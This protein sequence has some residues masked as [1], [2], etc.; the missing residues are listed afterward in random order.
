MKKIIVSNQLIKQIN[1]KKTLLIANDF[2]MN[3][4]QLID[5]ANQTV[6]LT[7]Q[8]GKYVANAYFSNQNKGIGWVYS[9][10]TA[11][12]SVSLLIEKFNKAKQLREKLFSDELTTAF[13]LFNESGDGLGGLKI[14]VY[15]QY[16]VF[17][18]YNEFIYQH[19]E[20][21]VSAFQ[22][23]F[24]DIIG[25]YVKHRFKNAKNISAHLFGE[26]HED[27]LV[28]KENGIIYASYLNDG[29]M[30]GIFLDQ[31]EVRG[32]IA[33]GISMGKKVLNL[34]SYTA[35]F[36][37]AAAMGG[38]IETTS[39]DLAK[40]SIEKSREHF[41]LNQLSL[42]N[43]HFVVMDTF[44]YYKYAKRKGLKF[45]LI[46]IDPPSFARNKR[47]VFSVQKNYGELIEGAMEILNP[48]GM[49]IASTNAENLNLSAF[50][51]ILETALAGKKYNFKQV[52]RLPNDFPYSAYHKEMNYLKVFII[53]VNS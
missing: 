19:R 4:N 47:K 16:A 6:E 21:I 10:N 36:S 40:R 33:D 29:L 41:F 11:D 44:E 22:E 17:S 43:N 50:K 5:L 27:C 32:Q 48:K 24:P 12:F 2:K 31:R 53:E 49:I 9:Q 38:A 3:E 42:D 1:A 15:N 51:K 23:V 25:G 35:A 26:Q 39:V 46:I 7:N 45:D 18:F 8:N 37:V 34:F 30:T 52:F 28:I 13:C 20:M 14:D